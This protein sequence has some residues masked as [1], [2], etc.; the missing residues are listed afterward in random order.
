MTDPAEPAKLDVR[1]PTTSWWRNLSVVWLVP[2]LALIV[3]LGIAWRSYSDRGVLIHISF[4]N[5]AGVKEGETT[6]HYRDVTIGHV[7]KLAFSDDLEN[8][9][10]SVRVNT[11]IAPYLDSSA[12]FW[13]VH[14][15]VTTSGI[16]GLSTVLSGVYIEGS[17]D[18]TPGVAQTHFKGLESRP[19]V[20][21]ND[22]KGTWITLRTTDGSI[23][24]AGA[25][26]FYRGVKVGQT[27][28]PTLDPTGASVEI[29]AYIAAPHDKLLTTASRFWDTSGFNVS[30]GPEGLKLDVKSLAA[31]I[32]GG[33]AFNTF[34]AGG[35]PVGAD[36]Q[37]DLYKDETQAR[38]NAIS[39][40]ADNIVKVSTI[41]EGGAAGLTAGSAVKFK[42][43]K[44]GEVAAISAFVSRN[45]KKVQV[46]QTAILEIDPDKLGLKP[47]AGLDDVLNLLDT[48]V[49]NGVRAQL[50]RGNFLGTSLIVDFVTAEDPKPAK[51][52]RNA[53]PYPLIP[54]EPSD[55]PDMNASVEGVLE[56]VN[57]LNI[58]GVIEQ[59][60]STMQSI[61][62][63]ATDSDLREAPKAFTE[64]LR[65]A[66]GLISSDEAKA[67]PGDLQAVLKEMRDTIQAIKTQGVV[68]KLAT[69][70][71]QADK[72]LV[73]VTGASDKVP[74][75]VTDLRALVEKVDKLEIETL[76]GSANTFLTSAEDVIGSEDTRALP[77]ELKA[78]L[79]DLRTAID[80][81]NT[82]G[83][84][85]KLV[86][87]LE[88]ADTALANIS[89]ASKDVPGLVEDLRAVAEKARNLDVEDLITSATGLVSKADTILAA[90]EA[91]ELPASLNN[92][93]TE[94]RDILAELREGGAAANVNAALASARDA[95][96]KLVTTL[97]SADTTLANV[98][99]ASEKVPAL[100]DDFKAV[101]EKARDLNVEELI[102][103]TTALVDSA[104][105]ILATQDAQELP[106]A[107]NDA[108][109]ELRS[110]LSELRKG[111]AAE[112]VNTALASARDAAQ[113]LDKA[114]AGLPEL[115]SRLDQLIARAE[116]L[117]AA[118]GARSEFNTETLQM[119]REVRAAARTVSSLART[120]ERS[121]NS[122]LFGR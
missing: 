16:S 117:V 33:V 17:W 18:K 102:T 76:I 66:D 104:D 74:A 84:V 47:D 80:D 81:F 55:L 3:S 11:E 62:S 31:L 69:T 113:S 37:F 99:T 23:M 9:V 51:I 43:L 32:N 52:D 42:G 54:S 78:T 111:G 44:I 53:E 110:I 79:A 20:D 57:A 108:L 89:T 96:D 15:E 49:A 6:L 29:R 4:A 75:L 65:N 13:V 92:T 71:E 122:I 36:Q 10:V 83:A 73:G 64:L 121:P 58:E 67:I 60:I 112:N 93:L 26:V 91:K 82:Q 100:I 12:Q 24:A 45:N 25:P 107:L 56:R 68:E 115:T 119:L 98:S 109:L 22:K 116:T 7:E 85:A 28:A 95:A 87:T 63:V 19:L 118:Y 72:A 103:S 21:Q 30:F 41:F 40:A 1:P 88:S 90:P 106:A 39:R 114:M 97:D 59:A 14:P 50:D 94:V 27:Q 35:K 2:I 105:K 48:A 8:V 70:L 77:A 34:F 120:L 86:T 101:A 46:N 61:E 5:A 38:E